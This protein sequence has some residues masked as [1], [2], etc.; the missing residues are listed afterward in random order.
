[1]ARSSAIALLKGV[2]SQADLSEIYGI[3]IESV[4]KATISGALKS[5]NY[6]GNPA[7][8]SIEYKRPTNSAAKT[9]GTARTARAGDAI[10][11]TPIVC[12][13]DTHKEI[14]EEC[15]KFDLDTIGITD[16]M[17]RRAANHI[18]T[19]TA[20]LDTAFFVA[21]NAAAT[22]TITAETTAIK[23]LEA[24]IMDLE[25]TAN[26]YTRG[27]P[28][29]Q[30]AVV[31]S[32]AFYSAIRDSL[33]SLPNPNVDTAAEEFGTYRGVRVWNTINMPSG[34]DAI[35]M[36]ADTI[37]QPVVTYPYGEPEKIPLSN[38]Y[39]VSLFFDYGTKVIAADLLYKLETTQ[40]ELTD[41]D[42]TS[43]AGAALNG[44]LLTVN[45]ASAGTGYSYKYKLGT[46][47][48]EFEFGDVLT[49]GW[50]AFTT[51]EIAAAANTRVTIAKIKDADDRAY[52]R[53]I[54][55]LVKGTGT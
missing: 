28:R 35:A 7:A 9:Y 50:T 31:C 22:P 10:T 36:A 12:N 51:D 40:S 2:G 27:V 3:V 46:A 13:L 39:A 25:T 23:R 48:T 45:P 54:A 5:Q 21:A 43:A 44:T 30:I 19:M 41:L 15:A 52:A 53:G 24:L 37:G 33:D 34:T 16:L 20:T 47:Y 29:S 6:T 17:K 42:V 11:V 49:T 32:T 38:D 1:M 8:G 14:V 4:Q 26:D 55:V 18:D